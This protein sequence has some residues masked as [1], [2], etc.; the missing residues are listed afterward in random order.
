M[1]LI[2]SV[3]LRQVDGSIFHIVNLPTRDCTK[4]DPTAP[5]SDV[6]AETETVIGERFVT[7]TGRSIELGMTQQVRD[8]LGLPIGAYE[9]LHKE[10]K[11]LH[12]SRGR[13]LRENVALYRTS[14][15]QEH[16]ILNLRK[17][18]NDHERMTWRQRLG[19][20]FQTGGR[21]W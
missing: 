15:G 11:R 21:I 1:I 6:Y 16:H 12:Q 4:F 20:L 13:L 2:E 19:F 18:L 5:P 17:A 14:R 8:V 10:I 9:N 3:K 7:A